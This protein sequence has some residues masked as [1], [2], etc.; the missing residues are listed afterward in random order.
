M[1]R[2]L[3]GSQ[4]ADEVLGNWCSIIIDG[5]SCENM[6]SE[7]LPYLFYRLQ[8]LSEHGELVVNKQVEVAFTLGRYEDKVLYDVVPMEATHL[9]LGWPRQFDR[10]VNHDG[11]TNRIWT[12]DWRDGNGLDE[13]Q[14]RESEEVTTTWFLHGLNG[15][16][17][18]IVEL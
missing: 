4:K 1:V 9:L 16:I 2:R 13:A 15:E 8:W 5:S 12:E 11:V 7:R 6:A 10:K 14:I 17:Q 18:D 3:M